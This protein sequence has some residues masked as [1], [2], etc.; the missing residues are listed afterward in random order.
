MI[1][2]SVVYID[3][4]HFCIARVVNMFCLYFKPIAGMTTINGADIF[5]RLG[6]SNVY[7]F[8]NV[9]F[10]DGSN[11]L[12]FLNK[13]YLAQNWSEYCNGK[14]VIDFVIFWFGIEYCCVDIFW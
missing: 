13:S 14:S 4:N 10:Q 5:L 11:S 1:L 6:Q 9:N 12:G 2:M 7:S 3:L 8:D